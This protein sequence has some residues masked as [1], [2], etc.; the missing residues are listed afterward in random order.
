VSEVPNRTITYRV[1]ERKVRLPDGRVV[2]MQFGSR[3]RVYC[4]LC[5]QRMRKHNS[6][7]ECPNENCPVIKIVV[8][9][10][11]DYAQVIYDS[12]YCFGDEDD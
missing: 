5:G 2:E 10:W 1:F 8:R 9:K 6:A 4:P 12:T 7:Y 3:R 11:H